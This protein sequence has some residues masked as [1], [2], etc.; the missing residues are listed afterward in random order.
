MKSRMRVLV[1][2]TLIAVGVAGVGLLSYCV[3]TRRQTAARS[4]A[5]PSTELTG[6]PHE[7]I[8]DS[9]L[10]FLGTSSYSG[11]ASYAVHNNAGTI[12]I[13]PG[14]SFAELE[15]AFDSARLEL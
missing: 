8:S 15:A 12:V 14:F 7:L 10:Y 4:T 1:P 2:I 11:S 13:D 6:R 9:G 3:A 5:Q